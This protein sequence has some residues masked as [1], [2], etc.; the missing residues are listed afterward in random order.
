MKY[1][2]STLTEKISS[3]S[4]N[5]NKELSQL[6]IDFFFNYEIFPGNI[7]SSL[8]QWIYENRTMREGDT[9]LQQAFIPPVKSFSQKILFAVRINEIINEE[10]RIGYSYETVEGHVEKGISIFTLE[11]N[12]SDILFKIHTFSSPGNLLTR[13]LGPVVSIPYQAYCT[14]K[15]LE[16]VKVQ[17][18]RVMF[19]NSYDR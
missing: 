7:M 16:H 12:S 3:V 18:E 5:T 10:N 9:I 11:K 8:T 1:D 6:K 15:C 17:L 2:R 4:I 19:K 14:R 13:M